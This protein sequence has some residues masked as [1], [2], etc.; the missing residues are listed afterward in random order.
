MPK[1]QD[2]CH[3]TLMSM[4]KKKR[5]MKKQEEEEKSLRKRKYNEVENRKSFGGQ[6]PPPE[7]PYTIKS[8]EPD[9]DAYSYIS[10]QGYYGSENKPRPPSNPMNEEKTEPE[11][12][13]GISNLFAQMKQEN[14]AKLF[15]EKK[16]DNYGLLESLLQSSYSNK[17]PPSATNQSSNNANSGAEDK[18]KKKIH[19]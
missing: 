17:K 16:E 12:S 3:I 18:V 8:P 7:R 19:I 15:S 9:H 10:R 1:I 4:E 14:D 5:D 2:E 11:H 13:S 6:P